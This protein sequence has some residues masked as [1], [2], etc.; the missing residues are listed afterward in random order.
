VHKGGRIG[1]KR[2]SAQQHMEKHMYIEHMLQ[3]IIVNALIL[4]AL[5]FPSSFLYT[6]KFICF[7]IFNNTTEIINCQGLMK[8]F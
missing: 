1:A 8:I 5:I 3:F 4:T 2:I 7:I 6:S